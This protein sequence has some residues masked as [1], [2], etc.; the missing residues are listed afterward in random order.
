MARVERREQPR[1]AL[2]RGRHLA[3][4][5]LEQYQQS[6]VGQVTP[7]GELE[8]HLR[9]GM[10]PGA[11]SQEEPVEP[12]RHVRVVEARIYRERAVRPTTRFVVPARHR[13]LD[14]EE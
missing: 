7:R 10:S 14:S 9:V 5:C 3:P 12:A 2:S 4:P 6:F 11:V 13:G 8:G 1:D